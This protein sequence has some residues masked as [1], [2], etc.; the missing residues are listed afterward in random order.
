MHTWSRNLDLS[1]TNRPWPHITGTTN[2]STTIV[3]KGLTGKEKKSLLFLCL[4]EHFMA[5]I[6]HYVHTLLCG[7]SMNDAPIINASKTNSRVSRA[8]SKVPMIFLP[9]QNSSQYYLFT[10]MWMEEGWHANS[11]TLMFWASV[12][13]KDSDLSLRMYVAFIL[14]VHT[15]YVQIGGNLYVCM[16]L[17][18]V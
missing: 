5:K 3:A 4:T 2:D 15:P 11:G 10:F 16:L 6:H 17:R 7:R 9:L 14:I 13:N 18:Y 12:C 1:A 8:L